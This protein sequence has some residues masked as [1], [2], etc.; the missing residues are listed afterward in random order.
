MG[1]IALSRYSK[2]NITRRSKGDHYET[3]KTGFCTKDGPAVGT[4]WV[5]ASDK[6]KEC[7][8]VESITP[9]KMVRF[10]NGYGGPLSSFLHCV[11]RGEA[12]LV[13]VRNESL[14][15]TEF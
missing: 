2:S 9:S 15:R 14:A 6:D 10:T 12:I 8:E 11:R 5:Y 7:W 13:G 1:L 3:V 4:I